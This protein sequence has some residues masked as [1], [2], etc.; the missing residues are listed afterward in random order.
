MG[1]RIRSYATASGHSHV[2]LDV[3]VEGKRLCDS[4]SRRPLL[5]TG[6][7]ARKFDSR[8]GDIDVQVRAS[9]LRVVAKRVFDLTFQ[10]GGAGERTHQRHRN[11]AEVVVVCTSTAADRT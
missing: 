11:R 10:S 2:V 9:N 3:A 1:R 4:I 7:A 8:V 6:N 5:A